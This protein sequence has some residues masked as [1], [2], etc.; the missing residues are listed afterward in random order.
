MNEYLGG[1]IA[2]SRFVKERERKSE[3]NYSRG[4]ESELGK[5]YLGEKIRARYQ[6]A[7]EYSKGKETEEFIDGK[8][9]KENM[10]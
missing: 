3:E 10:K 4:R 9:R 8:E 6:F 2:E 7:K 5:E 1:K